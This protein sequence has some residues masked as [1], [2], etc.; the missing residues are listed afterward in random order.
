MKDTKIIMGMP[1]T[2]E[3]IDS[4]DRSI[5]KKVFDYFTY[6]D[7]IFSTYK[8]NSE[9]SNINRGLPRSKWC[10]DM[11][12]VMSL[13]EETRNDS[14][15]FFDIYNNGQLD[16]S[17][18]V[19]GW[20]ISKVVELIDELGIHNYYIEAGGDIQANGLNYANEPWAVGIRNPKL[21]EEIVK[22]V[23]LSNQAIATSGQYIRGHH[24]YNPKDK[25]ILIK[26]ILSLSVIADNI[27][28]ADRY[29]TAAFAMGQKGINFVEDKPGLEAYLINSKNIATI[30]SGFNKFTRPLSYV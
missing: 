21:P 1:I 26:D 25:S 17:G 29:A 3:I 14:T 22:I 2:L 6:V 27:Y 5:L 10:R 12:E 4:N 8:K 13:C 16:P 11:S 9:I 23:Y 30:T 28:D 7:N 24:I 19:K 20:A 18:L 15:G